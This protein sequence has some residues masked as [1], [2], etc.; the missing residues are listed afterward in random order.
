MSAED[1]RTSSDSEDE[2]IQNAINDDDEDVRYS[3]RTRSIM[4][5]QDTRVRTSTGSGG[6]AI[7][8]NQVAINAEEQ[9]PTWMEYHQRHTQQLDEGRRAIE[10]IARNAVDASNEPDIHPDPH[11]LLVGGHDPHAGRLDP[12]TRECETARAA[13][14]SLWTGQNQK[15]GPRRAGQNSYTILKEFKDG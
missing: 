2:A 11:P 6:V 3:L 1:I 4:K 15:A 13:G 7:E 8:E 14:R 5:T 9:L 10:R 12:K